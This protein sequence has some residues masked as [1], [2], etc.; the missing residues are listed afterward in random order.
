M[1]DMYN[2]YDIKDDINS[3]INKSDSIIWLRNWQVIIIHEL[4]CN[5]C[6]GIKANQSNVFKC[7]ETGK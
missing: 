6:F 3:L 5:S 7:K 1:G 2:L 4:L